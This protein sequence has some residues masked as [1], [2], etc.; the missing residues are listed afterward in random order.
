MAVIRQQNWLSQQRIDIPHLRAIESG[1]AGDFDVLAGQM[2]AGEKAII[3]KGFSVSG[4]GVGVQATSLEVVTAGGLAIN[5]NADPSGSILSVPDLAT[6]E[7]LNPATNSKVVG[8][9]TANTTNYVGLEFVRE[10]DPSTTDLVQFIDPVTKLR[11]P[12]QVP[13]AQTLNY[14]ISISTIP[15]SSQLN[16]IPVARIVLDS[17]SQVTTLEDAR[18]LFFR[19]GSGG[20][21]PNRT[22]YFTGWNRKESFGTI[23]STLFSGG[24]KSLSSHKDWLDA[25]MTRIWEVGGG[26]FWYSATADRNVQIVTVGAPPYSNGEYF[27]F[28]GSTLTW[29][30]LR[31]LFDNS[32]AYSADIA[33]GSVANFDAGDALYVD[34]DRT[35][36]YAAAW[37]TA[38]TYVI[39]DI[40]VNSTGLAYQALTA[41]TSGGVE[42]VGTASS[43]SDGALNWRYV[44]LGVVGGLTPA[45]APLSS[46]GT[47]VIPGSRWILAVRRGSQV[48]VRGWRY[49]VGTLFTPATEL[50]LGVVQLNGPAGTPLA[51]VVPVI[52]STGGILVTNTIANQAAISAESSG[53]SAT[54]ALRGIATNTGNPVT[55][56]RG[57]GWYGVFGSR[58]ALNTSPGGAGVYGTS[59]V[60]TAPGILGAG[61]GTTG[62]RGESDNSY[63]IDGSTTTGPAAVRGIGPNYG[64]E[65]ESTGSGSGD[66]GVHGAGIVI[67]VEGVATG[68]T[69]AGVAGF[70]PNNA[71]GFAVYAEESTGVAGRFI[72]GTNGIVATISASATNGNGIQAS[73]KG[74]G[75]GGIFI[76]GSAVGAGPAVLAQAGLGRGLEATAG[77]ANVG[78]FATG[79]PG[80]AAGGEFSRGDSN[81]INPA[82]KVNGSVD[83][84]GANDPAGTTAILNQFHRKQATRAWVLLAL[85][86]TASPTIVDSIGVAS[87]TQN[88]GGVVVITLAQSMSSSTYGVVA[89]PQTN[90]SVVSSQLYFAFGWSDS[91]TVAYVDMTAATAPSTVLNRTGTSGFRLFVSIIGDQ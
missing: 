20:D 41:G 32:S 80:G 82:I 84:T 19:L 61:T 69:G 79:G 29:S 43:V 15:F 10:P 55:G 85:N 75:S 21:L 54:S 73:G 71:T 72:G 78:V 57:S 52:R 47:G 23:D 65:G 27:D 58:N 49:P 24:D 62:V 76:G 8:G 14:R 2:L 4:V 45:K 30:G 87:V 59:D 3:I 44:G 35:K 42:P 6:S 66:A 60:S 91:P 37:L 1:V 63:G 83:F 70:G 77:A 90:N 34:L 53:G 17:L 56:V 28:T 12:R 81:I 16:V 51:P 38:T 88:V 13:L 33:P 50:A 11:I 68:A 64:V 22:G 89:S 74:T 48:F 40:V 18:P 86:G 5:Y 31:V 25:A 26:E 36:F 46:L 9:W 39:G 67:G 7:V